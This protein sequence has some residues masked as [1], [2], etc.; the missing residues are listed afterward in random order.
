MTNR[1]LVVNMKDEELLSNLRGVV[2]Y[3]VQLKCH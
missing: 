1:L 3:R 2:M